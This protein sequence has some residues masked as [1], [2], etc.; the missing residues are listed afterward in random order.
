MQLTIQIFD[1]EIKIG[2]NSFINLSINRKQV[3]SFF[4]II[5]G[6]GFITIEMTPHIIERSKNA[7][8]SQQLRNRGG[9]TNKQKIKK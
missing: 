8:Q 1:P 7:R 3:P 9:K 2:E 5:K 6:D 4:S